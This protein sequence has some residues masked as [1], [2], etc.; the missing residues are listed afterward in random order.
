MTLNG[1]DLNQRILII[2]DSTVP[3][4]QK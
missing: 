3:R 2:A 4:Y 1:G